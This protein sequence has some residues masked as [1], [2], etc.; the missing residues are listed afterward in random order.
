MNESSPFVNDLQSLLPL[1][2]VLIEWLG[3]CAAFLTT[4]S[5]I[6]QAWL[7]FRT[8]QVEGISVGMYSAFTAG[9]ALWLLYG[10][11]MGSWSITIAN[12]ITLTLASAILVMRLRY[13]QR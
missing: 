9:V 4:G 3:A 11:A 1:S 5:F 13:R 6:P 8:R 7:V 12:T 2:P 10:I